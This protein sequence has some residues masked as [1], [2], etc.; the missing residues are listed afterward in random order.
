MTT[1]I[2][3]L[4]QEIKWTDRVH[5]GGVLWGVLG[6]LEERMKGYSL[7]LCPDALTFTEE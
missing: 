5:G 1:S 7:A 6:R 3:V 2:R 4:G